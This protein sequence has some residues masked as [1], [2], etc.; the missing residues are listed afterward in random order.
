MTDILISLTLFAGFAGGWALLFKA[1]AFVWL[2]DARMEAARAMLAS[3]RFAFDGE[4][5]GA[6]T[7]AVTSAGSIPASLGAAAVQS[8]TPAKRPQ[9]TKHT[10]AGG[11]IPAAHA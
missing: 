8:A 7:S 9:V 2:I 3:T 6:V 10:E 5:H 1:G 4:A 11:W